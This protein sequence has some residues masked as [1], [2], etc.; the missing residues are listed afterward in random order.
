M[1]ASLRNNTDRSLKAKNSDLYDENL[2]IEYYY[3]YQQYEKYF[4]TIKAKKHQR[5]SFNTGFFKD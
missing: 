4:I 1:L 5:I 3:L 2:Y